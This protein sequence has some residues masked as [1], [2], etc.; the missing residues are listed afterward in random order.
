[1]AGVGDVRPGC[2]RREVGRGWRKLVGNRG[3][4]GNEMV[5]TPGNESRRWPEDSW[6][7][8]Q[9]RA[10]RAIFGRPSWPWWWSFGDG[11]VAAIGRQ[12]GEGAQWRLHCLFR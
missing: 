5:A 4:V 7:G 12:W 2:C 1:M 8:R 10:G 11:R 9:Q 3:V 6:P